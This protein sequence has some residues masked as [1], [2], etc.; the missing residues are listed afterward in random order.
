[1]DQPNLSQPARRPR[2][3]PPAER[4][5]SPIRKFAAK[6]AS[7]GIVLLACTIIA[8]VWANSPWSESY[9]HLWHTE[10]TIG[11]AHYHLTEP[12]HLWINDGLM[13][14]FFFVVGLE[15]KREI[16]V[17]ELSSPKQAALP[18]A[19]ALGG[20]IV[21]ALFYI[22]FN[23]GKPS[24][25]GWGIPMAT[26]IAFALGILAL[27]G[28]RVPI[29]L[30]IFLTAL[31]IVDDIG[32]VLVI[33][34]F[35]TSNIVW[36]DLYIG[37]GVLAVLII[38]NWAG[39]RRPLFYGLLGIGG[40]WLAFLLSGVHATVAGVLAAFAIPA[41][42]RI[43]AR[44]FLTQGR[45]YLNDFETAHEPESNVLS[46]KNQLRAINQINDAAEHAQTPLQRL[47]HALHPWV[48]FFIMPVFALAN[49]GVTFQRDVLDLLLNPVSLGI[50][51]GLFFGKQLG[52]FS[53]SWLVIKLGIA[54]L[55][56]SITWKSLYGVAVLGGIGFTMSLFISGLAFT[57][58]TYADTAKIGILAA[59]ILAGVLGLFFTR[60]SLKK[61]AE[62]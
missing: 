42:T 41:R 20:M 54:E 58:P 33:A 34:L 2:P 1:M 22:L 37:A 17:G 44:E 45:T 50:I 36:L 11:T 4:F 28:K 52:I 13:A 35:Y 46:N 6:E 47:E 39:I 55:P 49:A 60:A 16:L 43:N 57:N 25:P 10:L 9:F 53:F 32:A 21:P 14:V 40:L 8:L 15:I 19:A 27:L 23:Y 51:V 48:V 3:A 7:G 61:P 56:A 31:A 24:A 26:D 12:L 5:F 29:S 62:K 59:S 38:G 18:I 30:K